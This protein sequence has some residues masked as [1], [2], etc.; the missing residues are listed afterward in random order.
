MQNEIL[1]IVK[2][3]L[4]NEKSIQEGDNALKGVESPILP[5]FHIRVDVTEKKDIVVWSDEVDARVQ[6]IVNVVKG[7]LRL[8]GKNATFYNLEN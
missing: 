6:E 4:D 2:W 8:L 7:I 1:A 5:A 3:I